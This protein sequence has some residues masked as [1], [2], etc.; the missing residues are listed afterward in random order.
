VTPLI[1]EKFQELAKSF[2][3]ELID[4]DN[5]EKEAKRILNATNIELATVRDKI[6]GLGAADEDDAETT[7]EEAELLACKQKIISLVEQQQALH[8]QALVQHNEL[9]LNGHHNEEDSPELRMELYAKLQAEMQKRRVLV[10]EYT[11]A[12]SMTGM[13]EK[14]DMYRK[15]TAKCLGI[16]EEEV[17]DQLDSLLNALEEDRMDTDGQDPVLME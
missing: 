14:V 17:D 11:E 8:L 1:L 10:Q 4:R 15:L 2:D 9:M 12:L 5:S 7:T 16:K 3:D 13:G 6:R